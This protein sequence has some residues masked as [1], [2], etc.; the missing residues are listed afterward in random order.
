MEVTMLWWDNCDDLWF[1]LR[2]RLL[3]GQLFTSREARFGIFFLAG[4]MMF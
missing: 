2:H 3:D 4:L 1:A